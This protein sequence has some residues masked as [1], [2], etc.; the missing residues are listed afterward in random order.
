VT[1]ND[2]IFI[3]SPRKAEVQPWQGASQ[4]PGALPA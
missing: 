4:L 1:V 2:S 3:R